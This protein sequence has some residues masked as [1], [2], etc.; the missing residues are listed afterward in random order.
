MERR[1][2]VQYLTVLVLVVSIGFIMLVAYMTNLA[3]SAI[4]E[5]PVQVEQVQEECKDGVC[6]CR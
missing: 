6:E 5:E 1:R 4:K 2:I 3:H